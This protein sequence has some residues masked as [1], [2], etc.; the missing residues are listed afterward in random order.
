[1][2][3]GEI[4]ESVRHKADVLV[5]VLPYIRRF[6]GKTFVVK[7]GGR[8]ME[9]PALQ[10]DFAE[11]IS[12]LKFV[13]INPIVVH[14]GGPQIS[15]ALDKMKLQ[16]SFVDGMR[17]TD[18]EAMSVVEM[19]LLGQINSRI[20]AQ[21]NLAGAKAVG[22]SGKDG[23]LIKARKMTK[24]VNGKKVDLGQVGVVAGVNTEVLTA[25]HRDHFIP[26]IAPVGVG[27]KGESY[28]INA[29]VVAGR[30]A[31]SL[32]AEK[33]IMMTDTRGILGENEELIPSLR[34]GEIQK[35]LQKNVIRDGMI[36]KV[37][38]CL[39]AVSHGVKKAHIVDGRIS[40]AVL[41]EI[42]TNEGVGTE[43]L[44]K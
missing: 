4:P 28:N 31:E 11:D 34:R 39:E 2:S 21:I 41:L 35:L 37:N 5:E 14:G 30:L 27:P 44:S 25:L 18:A 1:M 38:A 16:Y 43:I 8:T 10:Q 33:M 12:L 13:G 32:Q 24:E 22:L 3:V 36:P 17:V 19:V 29:D 40:H 42:F 15:D 7:L 26:V 6:W 23:N 20:V 9:D